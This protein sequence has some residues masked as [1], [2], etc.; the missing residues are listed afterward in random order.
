MDAELEER[1]ELARL[2]SMLA[3]TEHVPTDIEARAH[4]EAAARRA[5]AMAQD[6]LDQLKDIMHNS[7]RDQTRLEAAKCL[8]EIASHAAIGGGKKKPGMNVLVIDKSDL[9][10]E[11]QRRR[12]AGELP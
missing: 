10:D 9:A 7:E 1:P 6:V 4:Y 5:S 11:L 12:K 3:D 2:S 8:W